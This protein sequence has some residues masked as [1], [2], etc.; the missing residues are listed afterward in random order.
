[1]ACLISIRWFWHV[2]AQKQQRIISRLYGNCT[3]H[4]LGFLSEL[5]SSVCPFVCFLFEVLPHS[6]WDIVSKICAVMS[7]LWVAQGNEKWKLSTTSSRVSSWEN[8]LAECFWKQ[9]SVAQTRLK[10][11]VVGCSWFPRVLQFTKA[12]SGFSEDVVCETSPS[13]HCE[14]AVYLSSFLHKYPAT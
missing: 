11:F 4:Q 1:M 12:D 6:H 14:R 5:S 10:T 3:L 9:V 8:W 7:I 13:L 2:K